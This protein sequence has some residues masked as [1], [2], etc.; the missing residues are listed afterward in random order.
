MPPSANSASL[1]RKLAQ[2]WPYALPIIALSFA[3]AMHGFAA[4]NPHSALREEL[5]IIICAVVLLVP[6][7]LAALHH[8]DSA[9]RRLGEP[10]GTLLLTLSV[11]TI[12]VSIIVSMMLNGTGNPTLAR[13]AVFSAVMLVCSGGV[14]F[15]LMLGALRHGEQEHNMQGTSAYLA[16]LLVLSVLTLILPNFTLSTESGTYSTGQLVFISTLSVLLYIAFL[17][18]QTVRHRGHFLDAGV[19]PQIHH[20]AEQPS[21]APLW[22]SVLFLLAGLAAVVLLAEQVADGTERGLSAIGVL[23]PDAIV[24]ALIATLVLMPEFL[25]SLKAARINHLQHSINAMLG[26]ALASMALTIPAVVA[27]CLF[28][29]RELILGLDN[30]DSTL[31]VL[32]LTL[33]I[34]SF[35][36]GRTNVLTGIVHLVIFFAYLMLLV[37]P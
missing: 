3:V 37:I 25:T 26:S 16:V 24:G 28:T 23:R 31:L 29:R 15:C 4:A 36:T 9:A 10:Y 27:V 1:T 6:S 30:R 32:A 21:T 33:C 14:G 18:I 22:A 19:Q 13:E 11:T 34:V 35:G 8:A 5:A 7:V 20:I 17:Y 12:E 2:I